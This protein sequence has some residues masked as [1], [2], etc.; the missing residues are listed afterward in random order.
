[1]CVSIIPSLIQCT[2]TLGLILR[3]LINKEVSRSSRSVY[4]IKYHLGTVTKC[5]GHTSVICT[6][7][8]LLLSLISWLNIA[9]QY[10]N[11][12]CMAVHIHI[13]TQ[14]IHT[15]HTHWYGEER[16][17]PA[18]VGLTNWQ[19]IFWQN[20]SYILHDRCKQEFMN[21]HLLYFAWAEQRVEQFYNYHNVLSR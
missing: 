21:S 2:D 18:V 4:L 12:Q 8:W 7:Q 10:Y 9:A 19:N 3:V 17:K 1:M 16:V 13:Y 11:N 15:T 20:G 14:H 5:V 6:W